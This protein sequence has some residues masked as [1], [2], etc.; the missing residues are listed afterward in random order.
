MK[1]HTDTIII[2]AGQAGLATSRCLSDMGIDHVVF[3]RGAV[4][5]RW[6]SERWSSL[7]LLTPNWMSRLPGFSYAGPDPNGFMHKDAVARYLS[8][9]KDIFSAPVLTNTRVVS[10]T[11]ESGGFQIIFRF[12][13]G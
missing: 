3:E 1:F 10:V 5:E 11:Q 7:H 4:G 6:R 2:G 12:A 9:Y 8:N 13:C